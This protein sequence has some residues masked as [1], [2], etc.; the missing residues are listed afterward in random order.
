MKLPKIIGIAGTNGSGKDTLGELR[1]DRSGALFMSLSDALRALLDDK[2][3]EHTRSN[4]SAMSQSLRTAEGDGAVAVRA[5]ELFNNQTDADQVS[6]VSV[7]TPGEAQAIKDAGGQIVWVD[8]DS[9][10]RY[11]RI[12]AGSRGRVDDH[13]TYEEFLE[14]EYNEMHP[15]EAGGGLNSAG[16]KALADIMIENNFDSVEA[17][18]RYLIAEFEL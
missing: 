14:H 15:S 11:D 1:R 16:V 10:R 4:L 18:M 2:G 8:A 6:F 3:L 13:V 17:Y 9:R 12:T 5:I 7:R